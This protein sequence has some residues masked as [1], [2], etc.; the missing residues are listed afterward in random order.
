MSSPSHNDGPS[1]RNFADCFALTE[2]KDRASRSQRPRCGEA[3]INGRPQSF[4]TLARRGTDR[5][6]QQP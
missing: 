3:R 5:C 2:R 6:P 4:P 1:A